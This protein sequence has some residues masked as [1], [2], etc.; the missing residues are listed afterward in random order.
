MAIVTLSA[1][2]TPIPPPP[3]PP[4]PNLLALQ[5]TELVTTILVVVTVVLVAR[6]LF[7]SAIAEAIGDRIRRGHRGSEWSDESAQRLERIEIQLGALRGEVSEFAERLDFT[8]R[9]LAE[10]RERRLGA[11]Q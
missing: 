11:G 4:D 6:W 10:S 9:V 7:K 8:E 2:Q 1:V 5:F 3:L